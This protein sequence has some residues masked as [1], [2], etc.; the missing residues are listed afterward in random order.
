MTRAAAASLSLPFEEP[1]PSAGR[2]DLGPAAA[3]LTGFALDRAKALYDAMQTVAESSPFRRMTTPGGWRMSVAT[4]S[5]GEA[6]WLSDR[7]GYRYDRT[8]P[9]TGRPWP[10]L[11]RLFQTAAI[12]GAAALGFDE[13]APDTCLINR[14]EPGARL[15][16][17]Q[18]RNEKDYDQPVVT[19]SLGLPAIFL[20]GGRKREDP[21]RRL[22]LVHGDVMVWGGPDRLAFHG[23]KELAEGEHPL[24]G[25]ARYSLTFRRAL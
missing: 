21:A 22:P 3:V 6:G 10:A 11:P 8:D 13:F 9:E 2:L 25:R 19:V 20:W 1:A 24:A 16:L 7:R 23:V 15:S 12:E 5:C 14:Y 4:T 17:H 18:D